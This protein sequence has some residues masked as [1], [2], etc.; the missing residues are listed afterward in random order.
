MK[1]IKK[2][3]EAI[4]KEK[5]VLVT[6]RLKELS[7]GTIVNYGGQKYTVTGHWAKG[8]E[9]NNNHLIGV[10]AENLLYIRAK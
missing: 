4:Q 6:S 9:V 5:E 1:K 2:I 3:L 8:I 7:L 10:T